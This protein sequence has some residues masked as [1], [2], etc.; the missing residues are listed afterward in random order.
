[1]MYFD[2]SIL[3]AYP[4]LINGA[5]TTLSITVIGVVGGFL[6]STVLLAASLSKWKLISLLAR[7]YIDTFRTIPLVMVILGFYLV[8]PKALR[9][10][11]NLNGD[12]RYQAA[13]ITFVIFEAAYYVEILRSGINA[14]SK[15]QFQAAKALGFTSLQIF[16][17]ILIPQALRNSF[18]ALITQSIILFQDVSLVYV[19]GLP[20]F[21][22]MAV[23]IG[24]RD[25]KIV[26]SIIFASLV[27]LIAC[28][29][30]Q[31]LVNRLKKL[32]LPKAGD[33]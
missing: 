1:M 24:A 4:L 12:I 3:K 32:Y 10:F 29:I 20:D 27:Y 9:Y 16:R 7:L 8:M 23:K 30:L 5:I 14:I 19:I 21:F 15:N 17:L 28:F 11:F 6:L 13:I 18:P 26:Q 22:G 33:D 2:I 31:R 25:G